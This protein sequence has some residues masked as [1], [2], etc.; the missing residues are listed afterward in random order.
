METLQ[1]LFNFIVGCFD[2][3]EIIQHYI[4]SVELEDGKHI[5]LCDVF[6]FMLNL[7]TKAESDFNWNQNKAE[8]EDCNS[9]NNDCDIDIK[10]ESPDEQCYLK[11]THKINKAHSSR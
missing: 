9:N 6:D 8:E 4:T 7:K 1:S 11:E 3:N 5:N 2:A 10:E